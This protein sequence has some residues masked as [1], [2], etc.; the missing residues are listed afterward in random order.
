MRK[1]FVVN[2]RGGCGKTTFEKIVLKEIEGTMSPR[3]FHGKILS[4]VDYVKDLAIEHLDWD[5]EKN[6]K[7]RKM[8][9]GLKDV[10]TEW[11]DSPYQEVKYYIN[12]IIKN[13]HNYCIF[14]D[15]REKADI[16]RLVDEFGAKTI[17][18]K[19]DTGIEKYGNHADDEVDSM[20]Y[21]YTIWNTETLENLENIAKTFAR[22]IV[23]SL[24]F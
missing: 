22:T 2:G 4:M 13:Y 1:I 9:S 10:L 6:L 12:Y 16:K 21:D 17:L 18:I 23:E 7:S 14:I 15:A 8:L 5:G 3:V 19:R 11:N 24:R 20:E